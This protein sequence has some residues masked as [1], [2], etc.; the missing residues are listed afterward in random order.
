MKRLFILI[1]LFGHF[2]NSYSQTDTLVHHGT[3]KKGRI[4][5]SSNQY[6]PDDWEKPFYDSSIKTAF[7]S[8]LKKYPAKY[9]DKPIHLIGIVDSIYIDSSKTVTF[10]LE[11]KYWDY[12]EDY[13]IQDEK[14][15]VSA[16]GDGNFFVTLSNISLDQIENFKRFP[17]E[18]KLFL[19]YGGFKELNNNIPVLTARQIKY[20]DYEIYTT[21]I[22]SYEIQR[23]KNGNV[24]TDKKGKVQTTNFKFLKVAKAGQ[25]K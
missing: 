8:D 3:F 20:F 4:L 13:S 15:F 17:S 25:N 12:I 5:M 16:K 11:N 2:H 10:L 21:T 9:L 6:K 24:V 7:P 1:L 14:M 18:H 23:D 19:V 22:F